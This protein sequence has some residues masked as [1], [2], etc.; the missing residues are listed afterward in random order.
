MVLHT[1]TRAADGC[2]AVDGDRADGGSVDILLQETQRYLDWDF[3][4]E[5]QPFQNDHFLVLGKDA[6]RVRD[7]SYTG[8]LADSDHRAIKC[9]L[10]IKLRLA[11]EKVKSERSKLTMKDYS[12]LVG[13]DEEAAAARLAFAV[14]AEL[15]RVPS[16]NVAET[17]ST[18]HH[19]TLV[20]A[21]LKVSSELEDWVQVADPGWWVDAADSL[22]PLVDG[23]NAVRALIMIAP[24]ARPLRRRLKA[25]RMQLKVEVKAAKTSWVWR[26]W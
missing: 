10:R 20:K 11:K 14:E 6:H 9:T 24:R 18:W 23:R 21:V 8:D 5:K 4:K 12:D 2:Y 26:S 7:C 15:D 1:K 19:G 13:E 17:S 3:D 22:K 16:P 25:L